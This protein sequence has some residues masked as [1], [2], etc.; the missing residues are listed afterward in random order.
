MNDQ[1]LLPCWSSWQL[2]GACVAFS[3]ILQINKP[4]Q[5]I[6]Q[7]E[8]AVTPSVKSAFLHCSKN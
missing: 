1:L 2:I 5:S 8:L 6:S 3:F 4:L 7:S